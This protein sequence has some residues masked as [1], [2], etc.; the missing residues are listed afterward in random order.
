MLLYVVGSSVSYTTLLT[1]MVCWLFTCMVDG[2]CG[3]VGICSSAGVGLAGLMNGVFWHRV[4]VFR[5][6]MG[7]VGGAVGGSWGKGKFG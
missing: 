4:V 5:C 6:G 1:L 7:S 2:S 3:N